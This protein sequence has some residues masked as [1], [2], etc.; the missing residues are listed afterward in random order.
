M[1]FSILSLSPV[2]DTFKCATI[3]VWRTRVSYKYNFIFIFILMVQA[4]DHFYL[5][6]LYMPKKFYFPYY[7]LLNNIKWKLLYIVDDTEI[8]L[9][10]YS[11]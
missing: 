4:F 8:K 6:V 9:I 10:I 3:A 1:T 2:Q 11:K 5:C 7:L